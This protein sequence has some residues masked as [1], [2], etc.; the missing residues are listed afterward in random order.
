[1]IEKKLFKDYLPR[2]EGKTGGKKKAAKALIL[3]R[4]TGAQIIQIAI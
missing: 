1:M 2:F 3:N 4:K